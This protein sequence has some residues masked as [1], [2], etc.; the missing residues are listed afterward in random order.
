MPTTLQIPLQIS[1]REQIKQTWAFAKLA[2]K[3]KTYKRRPPTRYSII[4]SCSRQAKLLGVHAG[5]RYHE[6]K[7]L[8]PGIKILVIGGGNV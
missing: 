2:P 4:T 7:L 6:A 5:M 8:V 3:N 1:T